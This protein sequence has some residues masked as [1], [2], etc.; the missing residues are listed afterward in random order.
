VKRIGIWR[1]LSEAQARLY[2]GELHLFGSTVGRKSNAT[3]VD[4]L[5]ITRRRNV[6]SNLKRLKAEFKLK[7]NKR[8]DV[9]LLHRTQVRHIIDFKRRCG[10]RKVIG[11]GKGSI[12]H[13]STIH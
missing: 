6:R 12:L 10:P 2:I 1:W 4:L 11:Y 5:I 8:L 9:Q 13:D 7:F 3:D